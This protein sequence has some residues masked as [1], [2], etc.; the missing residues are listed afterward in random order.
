MSRRG[1]SVR[2]RRPARGHPFAT[3]ALALGVAA[4]GL[5]AAG[6][7][8][9]GGYA[10]S[11]AAALAPRSPAPCVLSGPQRR[12]VALALADIRQLRRIK[13]RMRSFSEHGAPNQ[14]RLTGK[15]LL[16]L[17]STSLP[18]NEFSHLLHLAK[19]AVN[20]CGDCSTGLETEEPFLGDRVHRRCG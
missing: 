19:T 20:L 18:L 13:T 16:D 5:A 11:T 7:G 8:N 9:S 6:C 1:L 12:T 17:G 10:V 15:F 14:E 4:L 3:G 2:G